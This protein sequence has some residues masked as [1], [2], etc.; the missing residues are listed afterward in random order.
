LFKGIFKEPVPDPNVQKQSRIDKMR[1]VYELRLKDVPDTATSQQY[2]T[3]PRRI[4]EPIQLPI[5]P[6][7]PPPPVSV[8]DSAPPLPDT[9]EKEAEELVEWTKEL[10][11]EIQ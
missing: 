9:W 2:D 5:V 7:E 8:P 11:A 1:K 10:P 4:E 3:K 6:Q